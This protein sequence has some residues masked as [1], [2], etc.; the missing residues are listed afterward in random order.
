MLTD[1]GTH[2]QKHFEEALKRN[3]IDHNYSRPYHPQANGLVE[4]SMRTIK[5]ALGKLLEEDSS[6]AKRWD[7]IMND[8][9]RGYNWSK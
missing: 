5:T 2:F 7:L 6:Q 8:I 9:V 1:Q 3:A 4:R